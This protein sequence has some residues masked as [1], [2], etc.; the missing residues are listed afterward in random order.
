MENNLLA[1][2]HWPNTVEKNGLQRM[3]LAI[4]Q[5]PFSGIELMVDNL[6]CAG[7]PETLELEVH[8]T[9]SRS[10]WNIIY[11]MARRLMQMG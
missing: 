4:S 2:P 6:G 5:L 3:L 7:P 8:D 10:V 1:P 11:D 9:G